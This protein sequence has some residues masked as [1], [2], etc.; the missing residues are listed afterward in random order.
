M[1]VMLLASSARLRS[2]AIAASRAR[3]SSSNRFTSPI[4]RALIEYYERQLKAELAA[5]EEERRRQE[6]ERKAA[7]NSP[8]G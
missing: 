6:E 5:R 1:S 7:E 3:R 8:F 2:S 4:A